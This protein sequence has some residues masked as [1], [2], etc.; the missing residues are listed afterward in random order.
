MK[1]DARFPT[2]R[3]TLDDNRFVVTQVH[4]RNLRRIRQLNQFS[5]A[6]SCRRSN[7]NRRYHHRGC[8]RGAKHCSVPINLTSAGGDTMRCEQQVAATIPFVFGDCGD[9]A[10]RPSIEFDPLPQFSVAD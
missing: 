2:P 5:H 6:P 9:R 7:N 3:R 1:C 8:A 4:C 10:K